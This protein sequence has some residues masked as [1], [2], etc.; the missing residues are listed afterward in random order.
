VHTEIWT[1]IPWE[2]DEGISI[3]IVDIAI[4]KFHVYHGIQLKG[5]ISD[6]LLLVSLQLSQISI[7]EVMQMLM[8]REVN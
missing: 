6:T 1:V 2:E 7:Q 3:G 8:S 5:L 4:N